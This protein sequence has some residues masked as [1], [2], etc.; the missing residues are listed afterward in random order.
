MFVLSALVYPVLLA[1]LCTGA[2]LLVDRASGGFLSWPLLPAVGAAA[3]IA[4][5]QL[6]TYLTP[7]APATPYLL[8][9]AAAGGFAISWPRAAGLARRWRSH[10]WQL[11]VPVLAY[12]LALAPVLLAG[13]PTFS[14]YMALADSAVHMIG[15]DFLLNHG[16]QYL[17]LDLRNSYGQFI[18]AY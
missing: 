13:R 2:G 12:A 18:N 8:A 4:I 16:Q 14:S 6:T 7:L 1:V 9:A 10:R 5:S 11:L 15:A 17:H 3:L